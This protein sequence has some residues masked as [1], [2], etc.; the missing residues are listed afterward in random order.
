MSFKRRSISPEDREVSKGVADGEVVG[1][2]RGERG[3]SLAIAVFSNGASDDATSTAG[4][5]KGGAG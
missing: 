2:W 5:G 1:L 3:G 4:A